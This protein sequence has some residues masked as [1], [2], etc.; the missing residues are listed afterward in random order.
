MTSLTIPGPAQ[1]DLEGRSVRD[2]V[3]YSHEQVNDVWCR[4]ILRKI[5]QSLELQYAMQM[6][7]RDITPDTIVFHANGEPL[8]ISNDI[9][10][11][12]APDSR[13][14]DDLTALARVLHYAIT[15]ELAPTGPLDGRVDGYSA[16][17]I[18]TID[19]CMDPDPARRPRRVDAVRSALGIVATEPPAGAITLPKVPTPSGPDLHSTIVA[20]ASDAGMATAP[21]G[22]AGGSAASVPGVPS[23]TSTASALPPA[24]PPGPVERTIPDPVAGASLAG[25]GAPPDP[26]AKAHRAGMRRGKRWAIAAGGGVIAVAIALLLSAELRDS[27]SYDHVAL[28]PPQTGN[29]TQRGLPAPGGAASRETVAMDARSD[30]VADGAL[31][32]PNDAAPATAPD[33]AGPAAGRTAR[34]VTGDPTANRASDLVGSSALGASSGGTTLSGGSHQREGMNPV[35]SNPAGTADSVPATVTPAVSARAAAAAP[36]RRKAAADARAAAAP[37]AVSG[38]AVY[39]LQIKPWG[40]ISVDGVDLGVSPP[41][42]HLALTPG[43][44]TVR[45]TNP[46]Y[47]DSI[48]EFDSA[49]T[50]SIGKIIVEF[51]DEV[52]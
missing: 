27:G 33:S 41:L 23:A 17:L 52:Q 9:D 29:G 10:A 37:S 4:K 18:A 42:R 22:A 39:Q 44:H 47:R 21:T 8:L 6:P 38:K 49:Q 36:S 15:Q 12:P 35:A 34:N 5:L 16:A 43:R 26:A 24:A 45:V 25:T 46:K 51:T 14:A 32:D 19:A 3:E 20:G 31:D 2:V 1:Q 11:A 13:E 30:Q 40:V 50:T 48:L 28:T 7:H